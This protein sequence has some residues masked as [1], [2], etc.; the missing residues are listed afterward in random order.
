MPLLAATFA[1][2]P[3]VEVPAAA[4][5]LPVSV[6][7]HT[8]A[9]AGVTLGALHVAANP[10]GSPEATPMLEPAAPAGIAAPPTGV[11]VTITVAADS[12]DTETDAGETAS[13]TPGACST[14]TLTLWLAISPSPAAV[15]T[16][17]AD[18]TAAVDEAVT[19]SVTLFELT[20]EAGA[21]GFIDHHA[22]TPAGNPVIEKVIFPLKTPPVAAVKLT[23]PEPPCAMATVL[24]AAVNV[25][26][27]ACVT[28]R[29]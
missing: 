5:E 22:V 20:L 29:A 24:D 25:S 17:L 23:V 4:L 7:V 6:N 11:A 3:S 8:T 1:V 10:L 19:V 18:P 14:W 9:P 2:R 15:N 28:V 16:M 27:G 12:D 21:I 13:V 26:V